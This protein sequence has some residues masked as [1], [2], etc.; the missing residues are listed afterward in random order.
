[1]TVSRRALLTSL[2][3]GA[4]SAVLLTRGAGPVHAQPA[5]SGLVDSLGTGSSE[6][7]PSSTAGA[8]GTLLDY[9][10][11]VPAAS[12]IKQ[13]GYAGAIRYVSDRRPGA[14]WMTGKPFGKPEA[15]ALR[16]AGLA[17]V[18]CYQYGKADTA[19]W[20]G[21]YPAGV[22]HAKRGLE[23]HVAAGGPSTAPIYASVDDN[24]S[25]A[26]FVLHVAPYLMGWQ[27]VVGA[28]RVGLYANAPTIEWASLL[29]L[30]SWFWQHNW[31]T[32]N[33]YVHP[34]A[35]LQQL[36]GTR[37]VGGVATDLNTARQAAYGQW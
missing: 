8:F 23:L 2:A 22:K 32:P 16:A 3:A 11:G 34:R 26:Q 28:G 24:P 31:G 13:G 20:L 12:A 9:S 6:L 5:A 25:F 10:A 1:M 4:G 33:G 18:S 36:R 17:I 27:S 29:G 15:D 19:D 14:E 7:P 21:G 30:A 37:V 35:H